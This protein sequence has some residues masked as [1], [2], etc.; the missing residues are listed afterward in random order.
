MALH[1]LILILLGLLVFLDPSREGDDRWAFSEFDRAD[2]LLDDLTTLEEADEAGDPFTRLADEELSLPEDPTELDPE[3]LSIP[4]LAETVQFADEFEP[5]PLEMRVDRL[6]RTVP[7]QGDLPP[8][9]TGAVARAPFSGRSVARKAAL[10]RKEGGTVESEA[11]VERGLDWLA[12]HQSPAGYWSLD[13]TPHCTEGPCPA[14]PSMTSNT[15]ATG[16][17]LLPMLGAGHSHSQ[18][19]RFQTA[20]ERGLDWLINVQQPSGEIFTGGNGNTRM[21]SHAIATMALCEALGVSKDPRL[22]QPAQRA[23]NFIVSSQN[24]EGGGWRYEPGASGDTS[25]FGWQLMALRSASL[26]GLEIPTRTI[27][28]CHVYLDGASVDPVGSRYSYRPGRSPS[29]VMTAEAL[30]CR[31]Y[32]GWPRHWPPLR[33]GAAMVY[34]DLMNNGERNLYY[35]YYATPLLHNM[36]GEAWKRWNKSVRDRLVAN[37]I[38]GEDCERGSWDPTEPQPDRW[39]RSA[40]RHYVTCLALLTLEVYYRYLPLY[41]EGDRDPLDEAPEEMAA[42]NEANAEER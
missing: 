2:Q 4:D 20:I 38:K 3:T 1:S 12:R 36:G 22:V 19:G 17:A 5:D 34:S 18:P 39:G 16:L 25:V 42:E 8:K 14:R 10:L 41:R 11:A 32:L 26:A 15:A 21:Y 27:Q 30:L 13:P 31:Q 9:L 40:G 37:Q 29:P 33:N 23:V 7:G 6:D 24:P 28:G 35:W